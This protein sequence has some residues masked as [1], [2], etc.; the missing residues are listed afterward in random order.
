VKDLAGNALASNFSWSFTTGPASSTRSIWSPTAT[1]TNPS[2]PDATAVEVG[3]KFRSDVNGRITGIRF[4]KGSGNTETHVGSLWNNNDKSLLAQANFS[5]ETASGWQQ[6]T[7]DT[8]VA[9]TAGTTYV[10]SY[11]T[12][13]GNY[14]ADNNFFATTGVDNA[15]LH[16]LSNGVGAGNGVYNYSATP[17]FPDSTFRST[18]YW[19]DVVF[20]TP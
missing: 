17:V 8:P 9:I 10:V 14:A 2:F 1:P 16:A 11:H 19:V 15:P 20:T 12:T 5:G 13:V 7:F 18:N 4:Y 3:V 6:V